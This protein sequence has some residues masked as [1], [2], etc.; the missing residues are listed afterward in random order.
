[1]L[2]RLLT[3]KKYETN[4]YLVLVYRFLLM[5]VFYS[6]CR[7]LF[8]LF[9]TP[10]FPRVTLTSFLT[11]M[12]GGLMFDTSALLYLN[13]LYFLLFILPFQFK[14]RSWYQKTLKW[15]FMITNGVGLAFNLI[16]M[17]YYRYILK[18]TTASMFDVAA[19]DAGNTRLIARFFYDFWFIAVIFI[20][21]LFLLAWLYDLLKPRSFRFKN[22]FVYFISGIPAIFI[23]IVLSVIGMRGGWRHS[24]RPINMNNAGAFVQTPEEMALVQNTPFCIIRT[25]GKKAF[26]HKNYFK[27]EEELSK[28][29][30][31]IHEKPDSIAPMKKEN[32]VIFILES[33]SRAFVGSLNPQL[34]DPRDR[35][36]TPFL[37]SLIHESLVFPN[38]FANGSKSID[39]IPSVTAS[40]PA[41][42]L[43]YVVSERSGNEI[44]SIASLLGKVG[45]QTAFFH[46]APNGSMGFDAF[47]KI[48][49]FQKYYGKNEYGKDADF[50]GI[51]GVWDEPFFQFF[52][53]EMGKMQEPFATTLFSVSSHHPYEVPA[54]YKGKFPE[55]RI[56]LN[57]C[58][59]YTDMS[60]QK[61]FDTARKQPW[62]KNTLFVIT[63]DH[64]VITGIKEYYTAVTH[65][66]IPILF[67]K[68]DG[69]MKGVDERLAQQIDILPSVLS[70]LNY[71]YPYL[72]YGNN[73]FDKN[74][75]RF[76]INYIQD[77]YQM[78]SG[79]FVFH[80]TDDKL[81]AIYNRKEDPDLKN[82]LLG[83]VHF[84]AEEQLQRAIVQQ[85][86]NR[87]ADNRMVVGK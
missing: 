11:I 1:M 19:F 54:K 2:K 80:L 83:K 73:L 67:Y 53:R 25:W 55:G 49:G 32:V 30:T 74:S 56:P 13:A 60:L 44:N 76:V 27:S 31:P 22:Q 17:I 79:D 77:S 52:A 87:M 62:F 69:S 41:L 21:L 42:V 63:A 15:I 16:D 65:F 29:Y 34:K 46:G 35:S 45:Y 20:V 59:R 28:I 9:N 68:G 12:K 84:A 37:D 72:A 24:T 81:T 3:P 4:E 40:I 7:V 39:A 61:F 51:W 86:N 50:D 5:M 18:R 26:V 43:P 36:Y 58:I 85:F 38:G 66:S 23:L 48:A 14:F 8:Y 33:F 57:K 10:S 71:P 64:S 70:Y 82:N 75:K 78:L 6:F 47:T